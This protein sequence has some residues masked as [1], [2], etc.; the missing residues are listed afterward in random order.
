MLH[1]KRRQNIAAEPNRKVPPKVCRYGLNPKPCPC[2]YRTAAS[3]DLLQLVEQNKA[4]SHR[5]PDPLSPHALATVQRFRGTLHQLQLPQS[6]VKPF[7]QLPPRTA[8]YDCSIRSAVLGCGF[9]AKLI[10]RFC[11]S[12]TG[13]F[14]Y[15]IA[16]RVAA[17]LV[18]GTPEEKF[19]Q[20]LQL[21]AV[22]QHVAAIAY[23]EAAELLGHSRERA[24][25]VWFD[26]QYNLFQSSGLV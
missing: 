22:G 21:H 8:V 25:A 23:F 16:R 10:S 14:R 5:I 4:A 26:Y 2:M 19:N 18:A 15:R 24:K 1:P 11:D 13:K 3:I 7:V 12:F 9:L 6:G 17:G 20:G